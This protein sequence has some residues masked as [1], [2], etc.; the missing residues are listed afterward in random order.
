MPNWHTLNGVGCIDWFALA[1]FV[2]GVIGRFA[3]NP[4]VVLCRQEI[5]WAPRSGRKRAMVSNAPDNMSSAQCEGAPLKPLAAYILSPDQLIAYLER[6][7][8]SNMALALKDGEKISADRETIGAIQEAHLRTVPFENLEIAAGNVPLDLDLDSLYDKIVVRRRGGICYEQNLL[9]GA[10][11]QALGYKIG[12]RAG[13]HP[14]YGD[15]MDHIFFQVDIPG[16]GDLLLADVGFAVNFSRPLRLAL[17]QIQDD[18]K[19]RYVLRAAPAVGEGYTT[20]FQIAGLDG[21]VVE[22]EMFTFTPLVYEA[23]DCRKRCDWYC[24]NPQ[25]RFVQG[26]LISIDGPD[27]RKTLSAN[28]FVHTHDGK[29]ESVDIESEEQ[30]EAY[31]HEVFGI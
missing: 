22:A 14:K 9:F 31:L 2:E 15:D 28:H 20:I 25:S 13:R 6:I 18:G 1:D 3:Y 8:L 19:D 11:L 23:Q 21:D 24:S 10:A 12:M 30:Y 17:D 7:G 29:R 5:G 16:E 4:S 26:P 27:G